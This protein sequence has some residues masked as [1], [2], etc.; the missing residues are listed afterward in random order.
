MM[1]RGPEADST[2]ERALDCYRAALASPPGLR[3]T[4]TCLKVANTLGSMPGR[5]EE[6][7]EQ[8]LRCTEAAPTREALVSAWKQLGQHSVAGARLVSVLLQPTPEA[9]WRLSEEGD[10]LPDKQLTEVEQRELVTGRPELPLL[11]ARQVASPDGLDEWLVLFEPG[12]DGASFEAVVPMAHRKPGVCAARRTWE[13]VKGR[14]HFRSE[15]AEESRSAACENRV[16]PEGRFPLTP[17]LASIMSSRSE[18]KLPADV[19]KVW[20]RHVPKEMR[21]GGPP[22]VIAYDLDS[23]GD[24]DWLINPHWEGAVIESATPPRWRGFVQGTFPSVLRARVKGFHV[25]AAGVKGPMAQ[26]RVFYAFDGRQYRE[27]PHRE[28]FDHPR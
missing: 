25:I 2:G 28:E 4:E 11:I 16:V 8:A 23:D 15:P 10:S 22:V 1:K 20:K 19:E 24:L 14:M 17:F 3:L 27:V 21:E 18:R 6:A 9:R 7:R 13:L 12:F 26:M 5:W